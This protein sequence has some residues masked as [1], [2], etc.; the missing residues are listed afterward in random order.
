MF[1]NIENYFDSFDDPLTN[2]ED[3]VFGG[4][5]K[6]NWRKFT[7]KRNAI[8]KTILSVKG[9]Y[10]DYPM[11]VGLCELENYLVLK[12]LVEN[13]PL[14]KVGYGIVHTSSPDRRGVDVALLY[15]KELFKV[16]GFRGIR[17][18]VEPPTRDILYVKG[19][20]IGCGDTLHLFVNHWPS[21]LGGEM[22]SQ[23]RRDAAAAALRGALDSLA[24]GR[25]LRSLSLPRND[26][27]IIIMGDFNDTP[28]S[29]RLE[30][31]S[32]VESDPPLESLSLERS[33][34]PLS[35]R[36]SDSDRGNLVNL[37]APLHE[38]GRG[39]I[40]YRGEW[41]MIDQFI[42]STNLAPKGEM[43]IFSPP[44]LSEPDKSYLGIKPRRTHIGPRYNGGVSDHYP[45][46]LTITH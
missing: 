23:P 3:F 17:V 46:I 44:F 14:F 21:K 30:S 31:P 33:A 45:I 27:S 29:L 8:A 41:E 35:L 5:Y 28:P 25:L 7:Q 18:D 40:R 2:D 9:E 19:V 37:A 11:I 42:V 22:V 16:V 12:Q 39:T 15:R 1:W 4:K 26:I 20:D 32:L 6:W 43:T 36:G 34:T 10:G 24:G 38:S 13:T